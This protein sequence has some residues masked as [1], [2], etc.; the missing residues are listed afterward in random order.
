M[1]TRTPRLLP[2]GSLLVA[3]GGWGCSEEP[4]GPS[5]RPVAASA[6]AVTYTVRDLGTLGGSSSHA[7]GINSAGV[8]VGTSSMASTTGRRAFVWKSGR[9]TALSSLAGGRSEAFAVNDDGVIVGASTMKSGARRAVRWKDGKILNLGTL[10]GRNSEARAINEFG[11]IV[12]WSE[13]SSGHR[14]AFIWK[15]GVMTDIGTLGGTTSGANG[16]NRS[17]TVVGQSTTASGQGH[18]FRWKD[19]IFK[20]LGA[21]GRQY[22]FA[23]AINTKGQ[24]VGSIGPTQDAVG[25]ELDFASPFIY[26]QEVFSLLPSRSQRVKTIARAISPTGIVVGEGEDSGDEPRDNTAWWVENG[27]GGV[28]PTL[29]PTLELDNHAGAEAVNRAGTIV[30]YSKAPGGN[31]HAV[32]WRR[33]AQ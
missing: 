22:S 15:N 17:G 2:L 24:I 30:G 16:I 12:G 29:V 13:T 10:G 7:Y 26:Y 14:H 23:T 33:V 8:I 6:S 9:M 1:L 20:D 25:E 4:T 11:A 19:G 3:L 5:A 31:Y 32:V 18:A 28:L 27:V 21:M